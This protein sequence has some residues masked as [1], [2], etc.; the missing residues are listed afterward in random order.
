M[1]KALLVLLGLVPLLEILIEPRG[2]GHLQEHFG[3]SRPTLV[4]RLNRLVA[5]NLVRRTGNGAHIGCVI[6][7]V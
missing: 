7:E 3:M 5:M 4:K 6:V 1:E 2:T